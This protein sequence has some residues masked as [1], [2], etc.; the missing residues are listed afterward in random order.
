[1]TGI[2]AEGVFKFFGPS[3]V[4]RNLS[5]QYHAP[6]S[7]WIA[8][9][10]GRGKS[11][12]LA[13]ISGLISPEK[14]HI[15]FFKDHKSVSPEIWRHLI[16][17]AAPYQSFPDWLTVEEIIHFQSAFRPWHP[18]LTAHDIPAL[19][20]LD[21]HRH[22]RLHALSSG[23]RQRLRLALAWAMDSQVLILDEPCAHLDAEGENW[24]LS[25][26]EMLGAHKL[27]LVASNNT[28]SERAFCTEKL[29]LDTMS[30]SD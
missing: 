30:L 5:F 26:Y 8:G 12:L 3:C 21:R 18:A 7:V 15:T 1:M 9:A 24:Y 10:N 2:R 19:C 16:A 29:D 13:L 6:Q 17:F 27:I 11:T 28:P 23:M 25:L 4:L 14:G 22:K 20:R